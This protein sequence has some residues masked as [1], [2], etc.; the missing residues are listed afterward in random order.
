M[1]HQVL[2]SHSSGSITQQTL[3]SGI[4][5]ILVEHNSCRASICLYGGHVLSW[6]PRA[7]RD[8]FWLSKAAQYQQGK[9]IR[10]GIPICW[11]W[12]G[13]N[14]QADG[15]NGGNHGFARNS[16]WQLSRYQVS[17]DQVM[18]ELTFSGEQ[19]HA[20][21][22]AK[23]KLTQ[24]LV[25]G[26]TFSQSLKMTN[27][28][29]Q[30]VRYSSALHSYFAVSNPKYTQVLGL[31]PCLFD[32]KISGKHQ[33]QDRL[34]NC[35]GPIDRIYYQE[36]PIQELQQEIIDEQWQRKIIVRSENCQQWV[37]WNPGKDIA[38]SMSDIHPNGENEFVCLEAAN[39]N[40]QSIEPDQYIIV[41]QH[42]SLEPL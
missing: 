32:N 37:L 10:G 16:E 24:Q 18:I 7:Q 40:W 36:Q 13:P 28:S 5:V 8:V 30:S 25:F 21:W 22:P 29:E 1:S 2:T 41:A 20:M 3:S 26:E 4:D 15:T 35:I 12:F 19:C 9:A 38:E 33:Q 27:L 17:E 14:I 23:F 39:T 31:T 11:P 42:I 34:Q 6:Q